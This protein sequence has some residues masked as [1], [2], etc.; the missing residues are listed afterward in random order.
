MPTTAS[1][2]ST[3]IVS[4]EQRARRPRARAVARS[5]R[6]RGSAAGAHQRSPSGARPDAAASRRRRSAAPSF[7]RSAPAISSSSSASGCSRQPGCVGDPLGDQA[8]QAGF[9][10]TLGPGADAALDDAVGVEQDRPPR[11]QLHSLRR[12]TRRSPIPIAPSPSTSDS[13]EAD[14]P[15][16]STGCGWPARTIVA[17]RRAQVDLERAQRREQPRHVTLVLEHV[18]QRSQD[19]VRSSPASASA[20]HAA[21]RLDAD[22]RFVGAVAADVADQHVQIRPSPVSTRS[23]KSPPSSAR[24]RPAR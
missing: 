24:L 18:L 2:S 13:A 15:S 21:R 5:E 10:E 17:V 12:A 3:P 14:P 7:K 4:A 16:I 1:T 22:R 23:K 9:A 20:R 11:R 6:G 8:M 19:D